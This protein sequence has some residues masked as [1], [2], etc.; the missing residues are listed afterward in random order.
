MTQWHDTRPARAGDTPS[1]RRDACMAPWV[2]SIAP[3]RGSI[4]ITYFRPG[5]FCRLSP[6]FAVLRRP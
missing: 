6:P 2:T 4:D 5:P 1:T 3:V